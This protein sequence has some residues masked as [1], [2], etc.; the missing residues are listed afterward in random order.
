MLL[1]DRSEIRA[2]SDEVSIDQVFAGFEFNDNLVGDKEI[3]PVKADLRIAIIDRYSKL[4]RV[5]NFAMTKLDCQSVFV[6]RLE[7]AR[8]E[9]L[10]NLNCSAD[11]LTGKFFVRKRHVLPHSWF[12]GFL[13]QFPFS[14]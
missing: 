1:T 14:W 3:E 5:R 11:D 12:P 2:D 10:V 9:R 8:T 6:N 13:I 4:S 7:K